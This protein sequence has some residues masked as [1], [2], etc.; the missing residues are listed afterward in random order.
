[1]QCPHPEGSRNRSFRHSM[2]RIGGFH[3]TT[4]PVLGT[5]GHTVR[6]GLL[7]DA[8]KRNFRAPRPLLLGSLN[9]ARRAKFERKII[10]A[11]V[12]TSTKSSGHRIWGRVSPSDDHPAEPNHPFLTYLTDS[13]PFQSA[14]MRSRSWPGGSVTAAFAAARQRSG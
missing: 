14:S 10:A 3:F 8:G 7:T 4:K 12:N 1:M 6:Y 5:E 11:S 13:F 2:P 9:C